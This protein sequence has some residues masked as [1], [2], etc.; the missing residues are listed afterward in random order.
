MCCEHGFSHIC[1]RINFQRSRMIQI[2][3]QVKEKG[4]GYLVLVLSLFQTYP[5]LKTQSRGGEKMGI[6]VGRRPECRHRTQNSSYSENINQQVTAGRGGVFL[7]YQRRDQMW[8]VMMIG[9]RLTVILCVAEG[10]ML[11]GSWQVPYDPF[12]PYEAIMPGQPS[13]ALEHYPCNIYRDDASTIY[14]TFTLKEGP[15]NSVSVQYDHF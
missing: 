10:V 15:F 9:L 3:R 13:D 7:R 8:R 5:R 11:A 14:C 1:G 4:R 12:A 2:K 6:G